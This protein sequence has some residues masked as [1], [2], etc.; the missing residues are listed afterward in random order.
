MQPTTST[1]TA[2]DVPQRLLG[3]TAHLVDGVLLGVILVTVLLLRLP[4]WALPLERDE[5]AYAYV[6]STWLHGGLPYR[7]AFDHKPP[8]IY[9][10]YMPALLTNLSP[11]LSIRLWSTALCLVNASLVYIVGRHV[12]NART[13]LLGALIFGIAGSAFELQGLVLN[14]DQ[15]LV[16]PALAAL[17]SAI[18]LGA[19]QQ[20]RFAI[21]LGAAVTAGVLIKPVAL[22]LGL[23]V[24]LTG[25]YM[26]R[27]IVKVL[28]G[29]ALGVFAVAAPTVAYFWAR[30]GWSHLLFSVVTYNRLYADEARIRWQ[31]GPL[32]DMFVPF[33]PLLLVALGGIAL[34]R[35]HPTAEQRAGWLVVGWTAALLAAAVGSLRAF[36]HYYYPV[37]PGLA[38]LAAPCVA[39]LWDQGRAATKPE[40]LAGRTASVLLATLLVLPLAVQNIKL[41]GTTP[42]QQAIRLY[43]DAGKRF[44]APA[45]NVAAYIREHTQA[46][47][48]IYVFAAEPEVYVLAQRRS[49][50]RYIYNYPLELLPQAAAELSHDLRVKP[51][52]LV[53]AYS[54]LQPDMLT[55]D[56]YLAK[57]SKLTEIGGYAVFG[58]K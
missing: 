44:F 46:D 24:V 58:I 41:V 26:R 33:V 18:N 42:E 32:V 23:L 12:W 2:A 45:P 7:D 14:T 5:G 50:S 56:P 53:I 4:G 48:Y 15:A 51:P 49:P 54:G 21:A 30:G 1:T 39:W 3:R 16:L 27:N 8:F 13:A 11:V 10:L 57:F 28:G 22:V 31:F 35:S 37:L 29:T 6:A 36:I 55:S 25:L 34:L 40:W 43:G 52:K 20:L 38:L 19:T 17:W 47:D 9:L